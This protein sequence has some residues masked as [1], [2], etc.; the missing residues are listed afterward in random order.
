M[1]FDEI[2]PEC[3]EYLGNDYPEAES[4]SAKVLTKH[5]YFVNKSS[6]FRITFQVQMMRTWMILHHSI[7]SFNSSLW[8]IECAVVV[9]FSKAVC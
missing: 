3:E 7:K 2:E 5:M 1:D 6:I 8:L 4:D 9:I